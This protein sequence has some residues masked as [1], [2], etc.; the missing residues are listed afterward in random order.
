MRPKQPSQ[1]CLKL[2]EAMR[3][4]TAG[5]TTIAIELHTI[6]DAVTFMEL[7]V[8]GYGNSIFPLGPRS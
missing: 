1:Y 2:L 7:N 5:K 8:D 6:V 3:D 4:V